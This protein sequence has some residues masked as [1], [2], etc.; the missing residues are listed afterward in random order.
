MEPVQPVTG[1]LLSLDNQ[2]SGDNKTISPSYFHPREAEIGVPP[3]PSGSLRSMI[4]LM[5]EPGC[6]Q[7]DFQYVDFT[8]GRQQPEGYAL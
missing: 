7:P 4:R 2:S 5:K 3:K 6:R 1:L 8:A